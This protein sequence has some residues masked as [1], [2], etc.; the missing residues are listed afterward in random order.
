MLSF[1]PHPAQIHTALF[2][3]KCC[4]IKSRY[5]KRH[6]ET[7]HNGFKEKYKQGTKERKKQISLLKSQYEK[8]T[9]VFANTGWTIMMGHIF[10]AFFS[11]Y[12][13]N[14]EY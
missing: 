7:K 9:M 5:L 14:T 13:N 2:V 3:L 1:F 6:Y 12:M 4:L 10:N 11:D 8:P